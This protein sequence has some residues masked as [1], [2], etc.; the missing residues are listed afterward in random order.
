MYKDLIDRQN[1]LNDNCLKTLE[2]AQGINLQNMSKSVS[3]IQSVIS[4]NA[5]IISL[6]QTLLTSDL[7]MNDA[8]RMKHLNKCLTKI[9]EQE[10]QLAKVRQIMA[11]TQTIENNLKSLK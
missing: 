5:S 1:R 10:A 7:K 11:H 6:T 4:N 8:E 9:K 2:Q 3:S